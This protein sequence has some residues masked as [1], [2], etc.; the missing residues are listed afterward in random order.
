MAT[1]PPA[2]PLHQP[3]AATPSITWTDAGKD[4]LIQAMVSEIETGT[5][6][7]SGFKI[8]AWTRMRAKVGA[9]MGHDVTKQQLQSQH[10]QL[11]KLFK[12]FVMLKSTSGFGWDDAT[13]QLRADP[14][15]WTRY[16]SSH[17]EATPIWKND[18]RLPYHDELHYI[19]GDRAHAS[20]R[21]ATPS[22]PAEAPLPVPATPDQAHPP[23]AAPAVAPPAAPAGDGDED[24]EDDDQPAPARGEVPPA[25]RQKR[26]S[27]SDEGR[28]LLRQ[29]VNQEP[30][31]MRAMRL[32]SEYYSKTLT[33]VQTF[34]LKQHFAKH[35]DEARMF[36]TL[37]EEERTIYIASFF[38]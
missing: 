5:F 18:K 31:G 36:L 14:I 37:T 24:V 22:A 23:P 19:F 2:I 6:T 30:H 13:K 27:P 25:R 21:Y 33:P 16:L 11:K 20:G 34:A 15:V 8:D 4:A 12:A 32:V 1:P 7:D 26:S 10:N 38:P 28:Q 29:L 3:A 35:E 9:V 17:K